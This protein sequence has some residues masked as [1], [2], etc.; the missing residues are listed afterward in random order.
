MLDKF[1]QLFYQQIPTKF[2]NRYHEG[3]V[4]PHTLGIGS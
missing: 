3:F 4:L 1:I 2:E